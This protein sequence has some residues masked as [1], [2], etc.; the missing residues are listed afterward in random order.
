MQAQ[1][2]HRGHLTKP[3]SYQPRITLPTSHNHRPPPSPLQF[4]KSPSAYHIHFQLKTTHGFAPLPERKFRVPITVGYGMG[5]AAEKRGNRAADQASRIQELGGVVRERRVSVVCLRW[6]RAESGGGD[7]GDIGLRGCTCTKAYNVRFLQ[8]YISKI[9]SLR[10]TTHA[11]PCSG[12]IELSNTT[13]QH[14]KTNFDRFRKH[15][16][17]RQP[18]TSQVIRYQ[19][20]ARET[21]QIVQQ[22]KP[23]PNARSTNIAKVSNTTITHYPFHSQ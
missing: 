19:I 9:P 3:H 23:S 5:P 1:P 16:K 15:R 18:Q 12:G 7:R 6:P 13:D 20:Q 11:V 8:T 22:K 2:I 4:H 17:T 21:S 14:R 10:R